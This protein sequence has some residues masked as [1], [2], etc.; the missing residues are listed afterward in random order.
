MAKIEITGLPQV[1]GT[2]NRYVFKDLHLDLQTK[3]IINNNLNQPLEI[4]D[5]LAD[6]DLNAIRNSLKNLF[7]TIPGQKILSPDYGLDLKQ[8][9]FEPISIFNAKEIERKIYSNITKYE[10]RVVLNSAK[11]V[12]MPEQY[13]YDITISLTVPALNITNLS[14]KGTLNASGFNYI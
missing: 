2:S 10:P 3:Y 8:F 6:F 1:V 12:G 5:L 13:E 11:V 9:L 14:L 4:K 7:L